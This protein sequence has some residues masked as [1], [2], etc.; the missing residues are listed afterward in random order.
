MILHLAHG[1]TGAIIDPKNSKAMPKADHD[2]GE[3]EGSY[4]TKRCG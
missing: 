3:N 1:M 4:R 2:A